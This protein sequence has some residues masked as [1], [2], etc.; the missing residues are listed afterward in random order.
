MRRGGSGGPW[1]AR[2]S[3]EEDGRAGGREGWHDASNA[4]LRGARRGFSPSPS[5][6]GTEEKTPKNRPYPPRIPNAWPGHT[7]GERAVM[8][9]VGQGSKGWSTGVA[10]DRR[11]HGGSGSAA[12]RAGNDVPGWEQDL[13]ECGMQKHRRWCAGVS[14]RRRRFRQP[15][16]RPTGPCATAHPR[17]GD[18]RKESRMIVVY[19]PS[20]AE[21]VAGHLVWQP[22]HRVRLKSRLFPRPYSALIMPIPATYRTEKGPLGKACLAG[23]P[24][25]ETIVRSPLFRGR[26]MRHTRPAIGHKR[27]MR[28]LGGKKRAR[29]RRATQP[30]GNRGET[31]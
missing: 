30:V 15:M 19:R 7:G 9:V 12:G 22:S 10:A 13:R 29:N 17:R 27:A 20:P 11:R 28:L 26:G 2:C 3:P 25:G 16:P 4:A 14:P 31:R 8:H 18:T 5:T 24:G 21:H 23:Q 1:L 6:S